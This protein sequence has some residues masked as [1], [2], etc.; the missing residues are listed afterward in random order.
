[1][2]WG[3]KPS[4]APRAGTLIG[5]NSFVNKLV[6]IGKAEGVSLSALDAFVMRYCRHAPPFFW[7]TTTIG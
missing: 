7:L 2:V 5:V 6:S 4:H 1:M 3:N